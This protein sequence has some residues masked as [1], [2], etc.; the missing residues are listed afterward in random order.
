MVTSMRVLSTVLEILCFG[1]DLVYSCPQGGLSSGD[2]FGGIAMALAM[3][4]I[5]DYHVSSTA[6]EDGRIN[7]N[8]NKDGRIN[9]KER[10]KV[11]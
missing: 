7:D 2:L 10:W 11:V 3:A 9:E 4:M 1:S 6:P 8:N 5:W